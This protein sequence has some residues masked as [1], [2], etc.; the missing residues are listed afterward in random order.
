M[1]GLMMFLIL[2]PVRIIFGII[3]FIMGIHPVRS[4]KKKIKD[5]DD[6]DEYWDDYYWDDI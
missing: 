4:N 3:G 1:F 2:L 5:Y 6:W